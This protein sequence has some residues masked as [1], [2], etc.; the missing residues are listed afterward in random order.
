[1]RLF[2]P[3]GHLLCG[4]ETEMSCVGGWENSTQMIRVSACRAGS[5]LHGMLEGA[6]G[7]ESEI[8]LGVEGREK[9]R[10][11]SASSEGGDCCG[12]KVTST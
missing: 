7:A 8:S 10:A 11:S 5:L 1:M 9:K 12:R 2:V 6:C 4:Q 3:A